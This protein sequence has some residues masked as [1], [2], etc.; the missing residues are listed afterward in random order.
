[1]EGAL[2]LLIKR[3]TD[4]A[5]ADAEQLEDAM[6]GIGTKDYLLVQRIVRMHW[7][8]QHM[9]QVKRAYQHRYKKDLVARV[10]GEIRGDYENLMVA[11]LT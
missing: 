3:A 6:A 5:M 4:P 9:D 2:V 7:N 11:C 1:M 8:R 10:K